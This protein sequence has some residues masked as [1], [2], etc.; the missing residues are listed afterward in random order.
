M[1]LAPQQRHPESVAAL[2]TGRSFTARN[3][4]GVPPHAASWCGWAPANGVRRAGVGPGRSGAR[5]CAVAFVRVGQQQRRRWRRQWRS[6]WQAGKRE[7]GRVRRE[8]G[9]TMVKKRK[10]RVVIDSDTVT[11]VATRTWIRLG[12]AAEA[13]AS[14]AEG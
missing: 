2:G 4:T 5:M 6:H 1:K 8:P 12:Q 10:G 13:R 11:A 7:S 9:T 3:P 14:G